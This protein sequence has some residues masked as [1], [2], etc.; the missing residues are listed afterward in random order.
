METPLDCR[1]MCRLPELTTTSH[2][3]R[4]Q[5]QPHL[6]NDKAAPYL[7]IFLCLWPPDYI[8][9][10]SNAWI[11]HLKKSCIVLYDYIIKF[12]YACIFEKDE[13][14]FIVEGCLVPSNIV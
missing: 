10:V 2:D 1:N 11:Q 12:V 4:K 6:V 7:L 3:Y 13:V 9:A 14:S 8:K 5:N